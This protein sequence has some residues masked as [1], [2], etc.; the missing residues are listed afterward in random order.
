LHYIFPQ[1]FGVSKQGY[2]QVLHI[3]KVHKCITLEQC[4]SMKNLECNLECTRVAQLFR[5]TATF[6]TTKTRSDVL[7]GRCTF[8]EKNASNYQTQ[9]FAMEGIQLFSAF[10]LQEEKFSFEF[11]SKNCQCNA[12]IRA[13]RIGVRTYPD[14]ATRLGKF[15]PIGNC[16]LLGGQFFLNYRRSPMYYFYS[17]DKAIY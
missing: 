5:V 17:T 7:D 6:E 3:C 9:K 10:L 12:V 14:R 16:F 15:S 8:V 13:R 2:F 4:Q 1:T 11:V